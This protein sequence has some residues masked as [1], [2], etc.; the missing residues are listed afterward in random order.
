MFGGIG[1]NGRLSKDMTEEE[2]RISEGAQSSCGKPGGPNTPRCR[3]RVL[4]F[5]SGMTSV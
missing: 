3:M 5:G 2:M 4:I 1:K